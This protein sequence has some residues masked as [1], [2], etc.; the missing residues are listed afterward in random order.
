MDQ[1]QTEIFITDPKTKQIKKIVG[2]EQPV[3]PQDSSRLNKEQNV[4]SGQIA[5]NKNVKFQKPANVINAMKNNI[6]SGKM[7]SISEA[8]NIIKMADAIFKI[9]ENDSADNI[10]TNNEFVNSFN[11]TGKSFNDDILSS[12]NKADRG[13]SKIE[14][15]LYRLKNVVKEIRNSYIQSEYSRGSG[16]TQKMQ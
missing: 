1:N 5:N 10:Y 2:K 11:E 16:N 6:V 9:N 3:T 14:R 4:Q 8:E 12:I 13:I 15:T 7:K